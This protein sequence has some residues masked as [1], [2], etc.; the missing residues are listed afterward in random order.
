MA[1]NIYQKITNNGK[2]IINSSG[3]PLFTKS[4]DRRIRTVR[5]LLTINIKP[6]DEKWFNIQSDFKLIKI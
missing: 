1:K 5:E 3:L 4:V 2:P 6:E